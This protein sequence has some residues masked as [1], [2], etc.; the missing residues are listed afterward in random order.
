MLDPDWNATSEPLVLLLLHKKGLPQR[1][2]VEVAKKMVRI[3]RGKNMK[4][5][6]T[7]DSNLSM[8]RKKFP[9]I[10]PV[11]ASGGAAAGATNSPRGTPTVPI[12]EQ[13]ISK[14]VQSLLEQ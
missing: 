10:F 2:A 6:L 14:I 3:V 7:R 9:S 13:E 12:T 11:S 5:F 8:L 4:D 1:D